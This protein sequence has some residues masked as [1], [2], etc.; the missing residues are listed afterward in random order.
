MTSQHLTISITSGRLDINPLISSFNAEGNEIEGTYGNLDFLITDKMQVLLNQNHSYLAA[1]TAVSQLF[2][3]R[4]VP[5][6]L[7][8]I[9]YPESS[10]I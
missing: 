3:F 5:E 2:D 10:L 9:S 1:V 7:W 8:D 4:F 6:H